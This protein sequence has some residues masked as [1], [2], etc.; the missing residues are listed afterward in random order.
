MPSL[1]RLVIQPHRLRLDG[2]AALALDIHGIEHLLL[3]LARRQPP[4]N[5]I[6]RSASVDLPWSICATM[7]K[8]RML[9][10]GDWRHG[11]RD[12]IGTPAA[13]TIMRHFS[14]ASWRKADS[15]RRKN[16]LRNR[17]CQPPRLLPAKRHARASS[18]LRRLAA[19]LASGIGS[20]GR[21]VAGDRLCDHPRGALDLHPD[22]SQGGAGRPLWTLPK[23]LPEASSSS[24]TASIRRWRAGV[25][26]LWFQIFPVGELVDLRAGDG[27]A[28]HRPRDLLADRVA[29]GRPA[30]RLLHRGNARALSDLQF[31]GFKY[32]P[33]LLQLGRCRWWCW[34]IWN[35]SKGAACGQDFGS[36]SPA[37][38][39]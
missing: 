35:A 4:V 2:D 36:A 19:W 34:P 20:P 21:P 16:A 38:W 12:S 37:R 8:L 25:A 23:P 11:A 28:R 1:A 24:V 31:Q 14:G 22:Q 33:D 30:P 6:R 15:T 39:R 17:S 9:E 32:N 3:H 5:W 27:D 10:I 26:G 18:K 13:A 7:A 29:R